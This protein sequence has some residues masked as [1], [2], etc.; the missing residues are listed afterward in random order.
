M[1]QVVTEACVFVNGRDAIYV[2]DPALTLPLSRTAAKEAFFELTP[3]KRTTDMRAELDTCY[4]TSYCFPSGLEAMHHIDPAKLSSLTLD[5]CNNIGFLFN[6]LLC[7]VS[8]LHLERLVISRSRT[9][10]AVG[11][12]GK[13]KIESFLAVYKGLKEIAFSNM[14]EDRPSLTTILAQRRSLRILKLYETRRTYTSVARN[15]DKS[16]EAEEDFARIYNA[17]PLLAQLVIGQGCDCGR[18]QCC[19]KISTWSNMHEPVLIHKS[20]RSL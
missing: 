20:S 13:E 10:S 7:N 12:I 9:Q 17:C 11:Y 2:F 15:G 1:K 19:C 6:G 5:S 3:V 8:S 18:P 14:G 4:F 16:N